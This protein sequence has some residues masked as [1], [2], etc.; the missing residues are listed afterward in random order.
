EARPEAARG[1]IPDQRG[2]APGPRS[3]AGGVGTLDGAKR[4][5]L[6]GRFRV[7]VAELADHPFE[8]ADAAREPLDG[9]GDGVRQVDPVGVG[10]L[11]APALP[12]HGVPGAPD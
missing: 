5:Q 4:P 3:A 1:A 6:G 7:V 9:L 2:W 8:R 10:P 11:D 12:A